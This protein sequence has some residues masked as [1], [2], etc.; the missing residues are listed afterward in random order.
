MLVGVAGGGKVDL[1]LMVKPGQ[2]AVGR[3]R[4][5]VFFTG[6]AGGSCSGGTRR[7][8]TFNLSRF[9]IYE[10]SMA[11]RVRGLMVIN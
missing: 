9:N 10:A 8:P 7:K 6:G 11:R 4:I 3:W 1:S 2:G 5:G